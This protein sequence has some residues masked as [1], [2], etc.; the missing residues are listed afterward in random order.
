[1]LSKRGSSSVSGMAATSWL[2]DYSAIV[3]WKSVTRVFLYA[4]NC[5]LLPTCA[6]LCHRQP[7]AA[8]R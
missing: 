4:R 5:L 2:R 3:A 1:M 7:S 6:I 8:T